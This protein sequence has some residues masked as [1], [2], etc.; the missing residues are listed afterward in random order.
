M[1]TELDE[2]IVKSE[3]LGVRREYRV[4]SGRMLT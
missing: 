2:L 4:L 3:C 1:L